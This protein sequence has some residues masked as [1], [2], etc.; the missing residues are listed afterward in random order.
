MI[1]T[2][3]VTF[4]IIF[5]LLIFLHELGHFM[6]ARKFGVRV[7]EFGFGLPPRMLG[8]HKSGGRWKWLKKGEEARTTIYSL[9]WIPF[10]GFVKLFGEEGESAAEPDSF[11][12][13]GKLP[14]AIILTAG[15]AMNVLFTVL[16]LSIGFMAGTP[17]VVEENISSRATL[18]EVL[19][20][21]VNVVEDSP[22]IKAGIEVGDAI[23]ATNDV[24][25]SSIAEFQ[26]RIS[27]AAGG[28]LTITLKNRNGEQ[29][30]VDITPEVIPEGEGKA[31]I[32]VGLIRTGVVSYPWY[33]AVPEGVRATGALGADL[34][35]AFS[36]IFKSLVTTGKTDANVSGPVG[37]AVL[38]GQVVN[39][40]FI[41]ILQ[42]AA[43]LSLNLAILN[44]IPFPAL[45]GGRVLFILIE[46][47]RGRAVSKKFE[48]ALH[49]VG[50][51]LL[52]TLI[53]FIT[54]K[55]IARYGQGIM[56]ALKNVL[57]G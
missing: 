5:G 11:S 53:L 19:V 30:S 8:W 43:T 36:G 28:S 2:T 24:A 25:V 7:D 50:F 16:L 38:T 20:Q 9:N 40:G 6:T 49:T 26:S 14:R 54:Y 10:G 42:F 33:L 56:S 23:L 3:I 47:L 34:F 31:I 37:I 51:A 48:G 32:G 46:A 41:Y 15:V 12:A 57:S 44:Y 52:I 1:L 13:K 45:D 55:D 22:A 18:S 27:E 21:V 29:R 39:L 4:I 35:R 17:S